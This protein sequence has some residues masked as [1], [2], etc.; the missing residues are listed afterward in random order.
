MVYND[1]NVTIQTAGIEM[2]D[3]TAGILVVEPNMKMENLRT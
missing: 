3:K 1:G 2:A